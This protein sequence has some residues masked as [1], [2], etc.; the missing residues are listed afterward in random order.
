[1]QVHLHWVK[2]SCVIDAQATLKR[3]SFVAH[4]IKGNGSIEDLRDLGVAP[5]WRGNATLDLQ[6]LT[7]SY[8]RIASAHGTL[9]V[10]G[11]AAV[12]VA[13]GAPLGSYQLVL[14]PDAIGAV[15]AVNAALHDT[16][17]P[18]QIEATIQFTPAT[19]TALLSGA[20]KERPEAS[21]ALRDEIA[22]LA[23]LRPRDSE[24]R[25]PVDLEFTL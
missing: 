13:D 8:M 15:G 10:A 3:D 11:V 12:S 19:G 14:G 4:D 20:L 16:G 23:Q 6:E 1:V 2:V 24:G 5:G 25:I 9:D 17:G 18:L 21:Q 22:S 7:G